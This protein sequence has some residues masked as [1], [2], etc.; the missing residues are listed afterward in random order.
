MFRKLHFR[1]VGKKKTD[2]KTLNNQT[3][4]RKILRT[5]KKHGNNIMKCSSYGH[6]NCSMVKSK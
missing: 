2:I 4:L 5:F 3:N 6:L 1:E